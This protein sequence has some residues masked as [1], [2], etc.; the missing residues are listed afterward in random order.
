VQ[1]LTESPLHRIAEIGGV[2]R[3]WDAAILVRRLSTTGASH[4]RARSLADSALV[5]SP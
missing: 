1:Q 5:V 3:E 4:G 2:E